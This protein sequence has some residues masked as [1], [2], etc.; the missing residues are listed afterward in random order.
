MAAARTT[1]RRLRNYDQYLADF[2][3]EDRSAY[4]EHLVAEAFSHI[5]HLDLYTASDD[6]ASVPYRVTWR[7]TL[8]PIQKAPRGEDARIF[9][10]EYA[11][12]LE[13]TLA[14]GTNQWTREFGPCC[15]HYDHFIDTS[16]VEPCDSYV[17]LI[18]PEV[19]PRTWESIRQIRFNW[20]LM[21][22]ADLATILQTSILAFTV[23][24]S[25]LRQLFNK[26]V[27]CSRRSDSLEEFMTHVNHRVSG[28]QLSTLNAEKKTFLAVRSYR[29]M[30]VIGGTSVGVGQ[31][32]QRLHRDPV[33]KQYIKLAGAELRSEALEGSL[34]E[35]G[36]G[37]SAGRTLLGEMVLSPVPLGD[38]KHREARIMTALQ[39]TYG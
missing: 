30:R 32:L 35:N 36:L 10:R 20:I 9:A 2:A 25:Q 38:F 7:G 16:S 3:P 11:A 37:C 13:P 12:L 15:E 34:L 28:W 39:D 23:T 24:H 14:T 19:H 18:T 26:L 21:T 6:D 8:Q 17:V 22:V 31:I 27:D 33:A 1:L 5:L 4:F 29:A